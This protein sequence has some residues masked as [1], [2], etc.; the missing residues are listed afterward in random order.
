MSTEP[1]SDHVP[2]DAA[3]TADQGNPPET[4]ERRG[5]SLRERLKQSQPTDTA[6]IPSLDPQVPAPPS[7]AAP[8][9][10]PAE[11]VPAPA[12]APVERFQ[13]PAGPVEIPRDAD[14]DD[15]MEAEIA[16]ALESGELDPLAPPVPAVPVETEATDDEGAPVSQPTSEEDLEQG[17][18]LTGKVQSVD[19]EHVFLDLGFR[20]PGLLPVRQFTVQKLPGVGDSLSVKFDRYDAAEGL[21][22]V[23][24]PQGRK[25]VG[26]DMSGVQV[27][28]VVDCMVTKTNKGGLEVT[29]GS[30]RAF[31]PSGQV[32]LTYQADLEQ[33]VGQKL[34]SIVIEVNPAKRKLVVSR[35]SYLEM[36]RRE[37]SQTLWQEL[38]V[39]QVLT[40]TVKTL[41]DYGAFVDI[42]G[43]DGFLHI[44]E[45]SWQRI[46]H[47]KEVLREGQAVDVKI[48]T[49][50]PEKSRIGLSL[51]ALQKDPWMIAAE[52]Y[53]VGTTVRG[54]V[55]RI[56][57]FGA[58]VGLD[59]GVEGLIHISELEHRRVNRVTEILKTGQ[60]IEAK[61]LS[62][63]PDSRRI[64]LSLKAMTSAPEPVRD[65]DLAP[66]ATAAPLVRKHKGPLKGGTGTGLGGGLFG[67]PGQF[68]E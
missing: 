52:T 8:T 48:V 34:P 21:I 13:K 29:I 40:G 17:Q 44:G 20:S 55:T 24:L 58:F 41:K 37:K 64:S 45:I 67:S 27:G 2:E 51:K 36:E 4:R 1:T 57:K 12:P 54:K 68:G 59:A 5:A 56:T 7:S 28:Q 53:G 33:F 65:E 43:A 23:S 46:A 26:G 49:L 62:V 22:H 30:L 39:G 60:D 47:P 9:A 19:P 16:A 42:G 31:M 35:R 32:D 38:A 18:K 25:S 6:A 11:D 15:E 61:V 66:S 10:A 14:L 63:D 3:A 50:E